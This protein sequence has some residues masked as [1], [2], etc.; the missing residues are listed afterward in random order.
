[1]AAGPA[2]E[3]VRLAP[4]LFLYCSKYSTDRNDCVSAPAQGKVASRTPASPSTIATELFVVPKS[5]PTAKC[6]S[7]AV[8]IDLYYFALRIPA[9]DPPNN[10]GI[11]CTDSA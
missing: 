8:P 10:T 4:S 7:S 1:M 9:T 11:G 5:N 3:C 2:R 6:R